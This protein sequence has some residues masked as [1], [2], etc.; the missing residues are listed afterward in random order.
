MYSRAIAQCDHTIESEL[1]PIHGGHPLLCTSSDLA[2]VTLSTFPINCQ[3][4]GVSPSLY[5][6]FDGSP[7]RASLSLYSCLSVCMLL[8][9]LHKLGIYMFVIHFVMWRFVKLI[10]GECTW[11]LTL[12]EPAKS[13]NNSMSFGMPQV[14]LLPLPRSPTW[15]IWKIQ[16]VI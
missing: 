3:D 12:V 13:F 9:T 1:C 10:Y 8:S 16:H 14:T 6:F 11:T 5:Y 2:T 7:N 4:L 15:T